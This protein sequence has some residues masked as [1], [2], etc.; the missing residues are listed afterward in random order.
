[1]KKCIIGLTVLFGAFLAHPACAFNSYA[2]QEL[3]ACAT[4]FL[5]SEANANCKDCAILVKYLNAN[6][7]ALFDATSFVMRVRAREQMHSEEYED[8]LRY[9][10]L[11]LFNAPPKDD[12]ITVQRMG[13]LGGAISEYVFMNYTDKVNCLYPSEL[14]HETVERVEALSSQLKQTLTKANSLTLPDY[15]FNRTRYN[16]LAG[17]LRSIEKAHNVRYFTPDG[18][19]RDFSSRL[20]FEQIRFLHKFGLCQDIESILNFIENMAERRKED[21]QYAPFDPDTEYRGLFRLAVACI[22]ESWNIYGRKYIDTSLSLEACTKAAEL[23]TKNMVSLGS[24]PGAVKEAKWEAEEKEEMVERY[25]DLAREHGRAFASYLVDSQYGIF[26]G[27]ETEKEDKEKTG[28][29]GI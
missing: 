14:T 29:S 5:D 13:I 22:L 21:I 10:I 26:R 16:T 20:S 9:V 2:V 28:S 23:Q 24:R 25:R 12:N 11:D 27:W 6:K 8:Y 3:V 1:M 4:D 19:A 17:Q 15:S 18:H 7:P